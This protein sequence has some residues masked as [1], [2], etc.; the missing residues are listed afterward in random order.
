MKKEIPQALIM[1]KVET[2]IGAALLLFDGEGR[3]RAL[4]WE[5]YEARMLQLLQVYN[6]GGPEL[7]RGSGPAEVIRAVKAYFEGDIDS[8][9]EIE[10]RG[11]GTPFQE[12]VW[13]ALR[14]IPAGQTLSYGALAA[15][16]GVPKAVRAVG[17]A[18]GS[19]PISVV[20]PCHRVIGTNGKLTGYGGGLDRKRWLL[21]HEGASVAD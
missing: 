11:A 12:A 16:I 20:V 3:L 15:Q 8:I 1:D 10:C 13:A 2:P 4:E 9:N 5:D 14:R 6:G 21:T 17:H 19:N 7:T 18:N